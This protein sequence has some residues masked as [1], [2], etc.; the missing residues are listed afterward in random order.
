LPAVVAAIG[1]PP[2]MGQE[3]SISGPSSQR[4]EDVY[5]V[6]KVRLGSGS[7]GVVW[8]AIHRQDSAVRAMK[9]IEKR[10]MSQRGLRYEDLVF[11][12]KTMQ[13]CSHPNIA[14]IF[15]T[16][17]D[18]KNYY[19][20]LEYCE[21]GDL[22]D[23]IQERAGKIEEAEVA[24]YVAQMLHAVAYM[25]RKC[26]CHRDLKPDNF[27]LEGHGRDA[28]LKLADFGI[29]RILS[30]DKKLK[31]KCGTPAFMA[32]EQ[33]ALP[34][35]P[36]YGFPVDV[37][38]AGVTA[39][40]LLTQ[41]HP[42]VSKSG[43]LDV[44]S[45][46]VANLTWG[47]EST[48]FLNVLGEMF[49]VDET[50]KP[51]S[52]YSSPAK[53]LVARLLEPS[54]KSRFTAEQGLKHAF[55]RDAIASGN[56]PDLPAP[57]ARLPSD[58]APVER[59][60]SRQS[61]SSP[62]S[63]TPARPEQ[64][65]PQPVAPASGVEEAPVFQGPP[66]AGDSGRPLAAGAK[67]LYFSESHSSWIL[68]TVLQT[69]ADWTYDL[70][71]RK[72]ADVRKMKPSEE[73]AWPAQSAVM[74]LS[75]SQQDWIPAVVWTHNGDSSYDLNIKKSAKRD[76]IR[77]RLS[78]DVMAS[79]SASTVAPPERKRTA[80][81]VECDIMADEMAA[82]PLPDR[83]VANDCP[84]VADEGTP[85]PFAQ[86]SWAMMS[87]AVMP[88]EPEKHASPSH[89]RLWSPPPAPPHLAPHGS[90]GTY[91]PPDAFGAGGSQA[92]KAPASEQTMK[93]QDSQAEYVGSL[94]RQ[95]YLPAPE[96]EQLR[97]EDVQRARGFQMGY[98]QMWCGRCGKE[99]MSASGAHPWCPQC[100]RTEDA[101]R[102][103]QIC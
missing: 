94:S 86:F 78:P 24:V 26:I 48:G 14:Q 87:Q 32:P 63:R 25:H 96:T 83:P 79:G 99:F 103:A 72:H 57:K 52:Q 81:A 65:F 92:E 95:S 68:T 41:R 75:E 23:K 51:S 102:E 3:L 91:G 10:R 33:H 38:A 5:H 28:K 6:Q 1:A 85:H 73:H 71:A 59:S 55:L 11:E 46:K 56:Y 49:G 54:T 60:V 84:A 77:A 43:E 18:E 39:Y 22:G 47:D 34:A 40:M 2:G 66:A 98:R 21:G 58:V 20:M 31:E 17:E 61:A 82:P 50:P 15:E 89:D 42:F 8:R 101:P 35:G 100:R 74:Y 4:V 90:D 64:A 88:T 29:A 80:P 7:F 69:N 13:A 30:G 12:I 62:Q 27:M 16:F 45:L 9:T 37:W 70:E 53:D 67:V 97:P 44:A 76:R 93:W 36:G 19:V